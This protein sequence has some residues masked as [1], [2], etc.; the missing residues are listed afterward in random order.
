MS[1]VKVGGLLVLKVEI[2]DLSLDHGVSNHAMEFH[3]CLC[4]EDCQRACSCVEDRAI[5]SA[6]Q[7]VFFRSNASSIPVL[8]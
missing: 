1:P 3:D 4:M 2:L 7:V 5:V 8:R 6:R